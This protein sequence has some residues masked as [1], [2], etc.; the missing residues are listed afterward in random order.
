MGQATATGGQEVPSLLLL[1][2]RTIY[3]HLKRDKNQKKHWSGTLLLFAL[4]PL[5]PRG[6]V[7]HPIFPK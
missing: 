3:L 5:H 7:W 4:W 2:R 6:Q 1:V